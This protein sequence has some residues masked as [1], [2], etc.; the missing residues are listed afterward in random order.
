MVDLSFLAADPY[1]QL[2]LIIGGLLA[3][4]LALY[5]RRDDSYIDELGTV[6]AFALGIGMLV[7]AV[8][9]LLEETLGW[10]SVVVMVLLSSCLF[11]KPFKDVPWAAVFGL[12]AGAAAAYLLSTLIQ[13]EVFGIEEW[14]ILVVV[15][16]VVGA[17]VHLLTHFL[18]DLLTI[19]TMVLSWKASTVIVGLLAIAEG[20]L[21]YLEDRSIIGLF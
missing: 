21:L 15:F 18:E 14:K 10:F 6:V 16:F 20:V 17:I 9:I 12:L 7:M 8:V 19:S 11:M 3:V 2:S 1:P 5:G 4:F 13:G